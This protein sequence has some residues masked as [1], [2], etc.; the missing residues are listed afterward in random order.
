[1]QVLYLF[2]DGLTRSFQRRNELLWRNN[3]PIA[4]Y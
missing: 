4:Y 1:M 3:T 2:S